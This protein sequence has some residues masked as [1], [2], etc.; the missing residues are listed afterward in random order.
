MA[1]RRTID[2]STI[3]EAEPALVQRVTELAERAPVPAKVGRISCGS[4]GWTDPT[5]I[6]SGTFYPR[7]VQSSQGRLEFYAQRFRL[8]EVDATYYSLLPA[9]AAHNWVEWTPDDFRFDVKAFP[10]LTQHP[11]DVTRLPSDLKV[12]LEQAGFERRVYP[13]KLPDEIKREIEL[14]FRLLLE[15]LQQSGKLA[16]VLLQFPPWFTATRG[17]VRHIETVAERWR[18]VLMAV[19]FRHPSWLTEERRARVFD[20]LRQ[21]ELAYVCVDEPDVA[22]GGVP[23]LI[24]VTHPRLAVLRFHGKNAAGWSKKGAS[25]HERFNYLYT[26]EELKS[27]VAQLRKLAS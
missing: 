9:T 16:S 13:D 26:P 17:N 12:A 19:E 10:V 6:K 20:M 8:V 5:L 7:G 11:I 2:I 15:P 1:S 3:P 22:S 18:G 14:R 24:E 21:H 4:A 23:P 25:V 27:W